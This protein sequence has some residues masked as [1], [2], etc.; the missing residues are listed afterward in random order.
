MAA[1][2][3]V[4]PLPLID[5]FIETVK[6]S[7][8][9][10]AF[11]RVRFLFILYTVSVVGKALRP[12]HE[13]GIMR[14]WETSKFQKED[15][16]W[17]MLD[18][19]HTRSSLFHTR[20]CAIILLSGA[21]QISGK[22]LHISYWNQLNGTNSR[23]QNKEELFNLRHSSARNAIERIFGVLKRRFRI[24]L[25]A[26]EYSLEVQARIPAALAAV[27]N[28]ISIHDPHDHP[29]SSTTPQADGALHMYDDDSDDH[30]DFAIQVG[31]PANS[32]HDQRRDMIA[33]KMWD[34]YV[35]ICT[36]RGIGMDDAIESDLDNEDSDDDNNLN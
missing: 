10:T 8:L 9:R 34:D 28:F 5:H 33:Q 24:L 29:I 26:P 32:I 27:H 3:T 2:S 6:G 12:M 19:R 11:L 30:E 22:D 36:E 4:H 13:F 23:P 18:F 25:L 17:P 31:A 16:I 15:T 21:V 14:V 35:G 7:S 1:T 20:G